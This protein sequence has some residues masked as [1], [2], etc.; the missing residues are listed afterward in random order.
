MTM[1][2]HVAG[3]ECSQDEST[4]AAILSTQ[5]DD[6]LGG[7]P[8]QFRE[9]QGHES[10]NFMSLFKGGVQYKVRDPRTV[11]DVLQS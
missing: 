10:V 2:L 4:S 7:R 5:L 1:M 11:V 3:P 8:V 9:L 6:Q